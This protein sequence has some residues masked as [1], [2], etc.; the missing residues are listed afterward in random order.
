[1]LVNGG[2]SVPGALAP[3]PPSCPGLAGW[4]LCPNPRQKLGGSTGQVGGFVLRLGHPCRGRGHRGLRQP[5]YPQG[6]GRLKAPARGQWGLQGSLPG[7]SISGGA[8][9]AL[10]V[11]AGVLLC[12]PGSESEGS[13]RAGLQRGHLG[14]E[15]EPGVSC[16]RPC[17]RPPGP[18]EG[19]LQ[20]VGQ[21]QL[22]SP[23]HPRSSCGDSLFRGLLSQVL[24]WVMAW[25]PLE[26]QLCRAEVHVW[27]Q[28]T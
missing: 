19:S 16:S 23:D 17:S 3:A 6:K 2:P 18:Q 25:L 20:P 8:R 26:A 28:W 24:G 4:G 15:A 22:V 12:L 21:L 1:M 9:Q 27:G 10:C 5:R 13:V 14:S 7:V 11:G